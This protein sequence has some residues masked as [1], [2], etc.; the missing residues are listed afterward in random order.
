MLTI[1]GRNTSSNVQ[2]VMWAVAELELEHRRIDWGGA[3]GGNDDPE[4]RKMNPNGL[5]P[6]IKDGDYV[7]WESAAILRYLAARYGNEAFWPQDPAERARLDMWA[8]WIKSSFVPPFT[9]EVF[10]QLVRKPAAQRDQAMIDDGVASLKKVS[11]RLDARL[12]SGPYLNGRELC[13]ADIMIGHIL[14]RYFTLDFERAE[15]RNLDAYY[16]R[17]QERPAYREHV[18][19]SYES[20][21]VR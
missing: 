17:L 15:N 7:V 6:T 12:G 8:E 20:L 3:F 13:F 14:Y 10:W 5:I 21:R 9:N 2:I 16:Q 1:W 19:V 11:A 18:M 4:Y